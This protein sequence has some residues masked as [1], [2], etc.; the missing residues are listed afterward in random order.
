MLWVHIFFG[1]LPSAP[2]SRGKLGGAE[3]LGLSSFTASSQ[4]TLRQKHE[5]RARNVFV[6]SMIF[7]PAGWLGKFNF[8]RTQEGKQLKFRPEQ[9]LT[10]NK[11]LPKFQLLTFLGFWEIKDGSFSGLFI[12][13]FFSPL[14]CCFTSK[15]PIL[16]LK[17]K[18]LLRMPGSY[19]FTHN[20]VFDQ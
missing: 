1:T 3:D 9:P 15:A 4:T 20:V 10:K 17:K 6:F 18:S 8:G 5:A 19:L 11:G 2:A 14:F 7:F 12:S 16:F 13:S